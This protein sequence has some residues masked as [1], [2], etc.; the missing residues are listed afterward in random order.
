MSLMYEKKNYCEKKNQQL[1]STGRPWLCTLNIIEQ[2]FE[3][4]Y[5]KLSAKRKMKKDSFCMLN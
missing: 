5:W 4:V 1:K 3:I 2:K